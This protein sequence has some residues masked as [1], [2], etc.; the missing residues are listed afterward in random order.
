M[1]KINKIT[2]VENLAAA[3]IFIFCFYKNF[4]GYT[5]Y[6][7]IDLW[8]IPFL[9]LFFTVLSNFLINDTSL[10]SLK[11][12]KTVCFLK[13]SF[14]YFLF[15]FENVNI[16]LYNRWMV[17]VLLSIEMITVY[18][19]IILFYNK[20]WKKKRFDSKSFSTN[21]KSFKILG[22]SSIVGFLL[23]VFVLIKQPQ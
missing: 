4:I 3:L 9:Y 19:C 8:F 10:F 13:Y 2:V 23:T 14:L 20:L 21:D 12:L 22:I 5:T 7:L 11:V 18:A 17:I 6:N 16:Y 1:K 15:Y